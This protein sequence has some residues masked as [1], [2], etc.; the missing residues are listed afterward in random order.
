[1]FEDDEA[2]F[3]LWLYILLYE[4]SIVN[5]KFFHNIDVCD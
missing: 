5:F 1:M 4:L 3:L 2:F